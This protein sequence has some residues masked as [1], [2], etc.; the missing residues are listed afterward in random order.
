MVDR[1]GRIRL[2]LIKAR[3]MEREA[4]RSWDIFLEI[5]PLPPSRHMAAVRR[6]RFHVANQ[7]RAAPSTEQR[8][9]AGAVES[10]GGHTAKAGGRAPAPTK[11]PPPRALRTGTTA[12]AAAPGAAAGATAEK[13]M[14]APPI[15]PLAAILAPSS[16]VATLILGQTR[17]LERGPFPDVDSAM[18]EAPTAEAPPL[19]LPLPASDNS[20]ERAL[21]A[22]ARREHR[23]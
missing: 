5:Q 9:G 23:R 8:F 22:E 21:K 3:R 10:S 11:S 20:E 15:V 2:V 17:I 19:P 7:F 4:D 14:A 12:A 6:P 13:P 18:A 16:R 1:E